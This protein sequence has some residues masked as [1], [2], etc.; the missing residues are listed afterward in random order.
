MTK[1]MISFVPLD[2]NNEDDIEAMT[3]EIDDTLDQ[4]SGTIIFWR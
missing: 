1:S 4:W 3:R 2:Q